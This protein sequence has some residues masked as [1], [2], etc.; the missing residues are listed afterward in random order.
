MQRFLDLTTRTK[1]L[2]SF[3]LMVLLLLAVSVAAYVASAN[4]RS[5][6][7]SLYEEQFA[8]A[9]NLKT[10]R[11]NHNAIRADV[12]SLLVS[13]SPAERE[14]WQQDISVR[15]NENDALMSELLAGALDDP[16]LHGHLTEFDSLRLAFRETRDTEIIPYIEAGEIEA[17]KGLVL[18][19]QAERD[20]NLRALADQL[21]A[22]ADAEAQAALVEATDHATNYLRMFVIV[23]LL[24]VAAGLS[25][26]WLLNRS[27]ANPLKTL[28]GIAEQVA[29]GDLTVQVPA[30]RRADEVG[31][32][33]QAFQRMVSSLREMNREVLT[34]VNVLGSSTSEI[35]AT[36]TQLAAGTTE[37]ASAVSETTTTVDEVRQVAEVA[38]QKAKVVSD[39]AQKSMQVAQ[40]GR[41][42]VE[43]TVVVMQ[44][45]QGQMGEV[46]ES[47][48]RLSEQ[49][50][51]IG[52]IIATVTDL[53][54][55]SNLLAV[56]A[57]IEAAKAGEQG[58]GFAVVA[59]EVR[60]L[61]EQSK[62]ATT[63]V[64]SI[65]GD[66]QKATS[67]AVMAAEQG[68]NAVEAGVKQSAAAGES[69]RQLTEVITEASQS[70]TQ[71]AASSQQQLVGMDQVVQAMENIN[72]AGAQNAASTKQ[73]SIIAHDLHDL[74]QRLKGL[75]EK[76]HV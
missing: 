63:Q 42:S 32:L 25:M 12:L 71:I 34:G 66:I 6:L 52:E 65:L 72:L 45:I 5:S 46:A 11:A 53:A 1:L 51:A 27:I 28:S 57:A 3:G 76:Y 22:D 59:Q 26:T 38:S 4:L 47:I 61:A 17:A 18:G 49:S 70:A 60:S 8:L 50:Q 2:L 29:A 68:A 33:T 43:D 40:A 10:I 9:V 73:A 54:E 7:E 69:I 74:G 24:A 62:Q 21:V 48:V 56:N 36:T 67:T 23:G 35:L 75:V 31:V 39:S 15:D 64:R 58:R 16:V 14:V 44:R 41:K 30:D 20:T 55:Q 37:T 13:T 19:I